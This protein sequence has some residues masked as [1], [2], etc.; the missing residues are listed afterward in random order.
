MANDFRSRAK[1]FEPNF[2]LGKTSTW[3]NQE[4]KVVCTVGQFGLCLALIETFALKQ[5]GNNLHE[6]L[7]TP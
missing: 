3:S 2:F 4:N 7:L 6:V 5:L 1:R